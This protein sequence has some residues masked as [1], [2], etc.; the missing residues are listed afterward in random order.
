[1][2]LSKD[3]LGR[4]TP[5]WLRGGYLPLAVCQV[6]LQQGLGFQAH[7]TH[8]SSGRQVTQPLVF[9][10]LGGAHPAAA[11]AHRRRR[12][13]WAAFSDREP[14]SAGQTDHGDRSCHTPQ[15]ELPVSKIPPG[16]QGSG[17]QNVPRPPCKD[18]PGAERGIEA[19]VPRER[20]RSE[21]T[22]A[23]PLPEG[24]ADPNGAHLN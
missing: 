12:G 9:Q 19:A 10:A 5:P 6:L 16:G 1:M 13:S 7:S 23:P 15:R 11:K 20:F 8:G 4:Q 24:S 22:G 3:T 18:C 21:G 17:Q 2:D 14:E